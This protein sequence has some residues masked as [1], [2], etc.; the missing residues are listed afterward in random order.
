MGV[1]DFLF[2]R[3]CLSCGQPG[4]YFCKACLETASLK[5]DWICPECGRGSFG[6]EVHGRC[7]RA[8]GLDGLISLWSYRG[9]VRLGVQAL[10]YD[11]L[12]DMRLEL[13]SLV[14]TGLLAKLSSERGGR[15]KIF[16]KKQPVLVAVPLYWRRQNWRGFNQAE[17][18]AELV[19]ERLN[20][21]RADWLERC[22]ST[23]PQV[24]LSKEKRQANVSSAFRVRPGLE[25]GERVLLVD[26]VW[27]TGAT[28]KAAAKEL[29]RAG[30]KIVWALTLA[31]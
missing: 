18:I 26:D 25:L 21:R 22:R 19:A 14:T 9:L 20:L 29:K 17:L 8:W 15:W 2:P 1:I 23:K 4:R 30:V 11:F 6:G 3:R 27:T 13:N 7:Q 12:T 10:K 16:L 24:K 28:I 5:Q 31:R